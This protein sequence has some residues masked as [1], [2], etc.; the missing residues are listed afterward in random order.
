M[1][2]ERKTEAVVRRHFDEY[3]GDVVVEEQDSESPKIAK[4]LK[5]ASKSGAGPG[6]PDFIVTLENEPDLLVVVECKADLSK[7]ESPERSA[8]AEYAVDGALHYAAHLSRGFD[9]LAIAVSGSAERTRVSHFLHLKTQRKAVEA[10]GESLLAPDEY[11]RGYRND[12]GKFRQ[13]FASLQAFIKDLNNRLHIDKVSESNRS[14]LISAVL[15]ALE[16]GAFKRGYPA[17]RNPRALA[18]MTVDAAIESLRETGVDGPRIEVIKQGFEFLVAS[19]VLVAKRGELTGIIADIDE[20][21]NSFRKTHQYRDVLGSLYIEFLRYANSDKGLGI[22]LTPPHVTELFA[23]LAGVNAKSVVYDSCAGT[24][25]FL[26]S[27]M[28]KMIDDAKGDGKIETRVKT[29]QLYGVEIQPNIYPLAVSNMFVHQDGK[30]NIIHGDCFD[31]NVVERIKELKPN[32]GMLN[33]PYKADKKRDVEEL[34]FVLNNL[35]CLS[36]GGTCVAI[37]PMQCALSQGGRIA[38]LKRELMSRHTLEAVCSMPDEL[39]FN[40]KVGVVSCIMVFTAHRPHPGEK[41]VFLGYF[42]DDGFEKRKIGG[43]Q[44][45]DGRWRSIERRWLEH[46]LNRR[47]TP[48]LSVNVSLG[49][50]DEWSAEAYMETDYSRL[51]EAVFEDTLHNYSTFLFRSRRLGRVTD[52][53]AAERRKRTPLAEKTWRKFELESLFD[54]GG[55]VTTPVRELDYRRSGKYPYVTTQ[56]TDNGVAGFYDHWTEDGGVISVDSAVI[57][58]CSYRAEKFSASDHV[59]TLTPKFPMSARAA[60]FLVTLLNMEQYRYNYGRKRSQTRL[61]RESLRLPATGA[62]EPDWAFMERYIEGVRYSAN[63]A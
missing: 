15:I 44:D 39:F 48:G 29:S 26:I 24:G 18:R 35:E 56:A 50:R 63:V 51:T 58:Y 1:P 30:T 60:M 55:T 10:F 21:V 14:L 59:E 57:G 28:K 43:R 16:R 61:R 37:A 13:D 8:Y 38:D 36:Q 42:K 31:K 53:R 41:N 22:V 12:P 40:S 11:I 54:I 46:Y 23:D 7:H 3:G 17:E 52:D 5:A 33:P 25:G 27:A 20:N 62:G 32:V 2:S 47:T 19:P 9:V 6:R 45:V 34:D 49:P 4:L